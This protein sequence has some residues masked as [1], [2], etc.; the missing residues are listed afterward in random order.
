MEDQLEVL[1]RYKLKL[2]EQQLQVCK[3]QLKESRAI[4]KSLHGL[5]DRF[6]GLERKVNPGGAGSDA[7]A[8]KECTTVQTSV[9]VTCISPAH[10]SAEPLHR[11]VF[12]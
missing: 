9:N 5:Q 2:T 8:C 11:F 6:A 4:N 1:D 10:H 12:N 3:E 7:V